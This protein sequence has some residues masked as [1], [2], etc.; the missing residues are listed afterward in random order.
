LN[1]GQKVIS[2]RRTVGELTIE[3]LEQI[4]IVRRRQARAERMR[5]LRQIGR[6]PAEAALPSED[7]TPMGTADSAGKA[8]RDA[9]EARRQ[10][11]F[12]VEPLWEN[13]RRQK[14]RERRRKKQGE[15]QARSRGGRLRDKV[16]LVLEIGA[17]LGLV[18]VLVISL[19]N[20]KALNDDYADA[21]QPPLTAVVTPAGEVEDV[22]PSG[23]A[24]PEEPGSVPTHLRGLV[25]GEVLPAVAIPTPGPEA[26]TRIVIPALNVDALIVEGDSWEQLKLGVGHHLSTA[27][28]GERGNMVL[29]AHNDIYGEIFRRLSDLEL[30]DEVIVYAGEQPYRYMVTAKQIV[31]P[32]DVS[33]LASTTK[34]VAT[35]ISCY[36][37]MVDTHRIVVIAELQ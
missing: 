7:L 24:P 32:T 23:H 19:Q 28:P 18:A 6:L 30:G 17:L 16:L 10:R 25:E 13:K 37:Y 1:K 3:E 12:D 5:R 15:Y 29:S 2:D 22:L 8:A 20:I 36:P 11:A 26:P 33:V 21:S 31:E 9:E 14:R 35:L 27:D 4:L 34:P